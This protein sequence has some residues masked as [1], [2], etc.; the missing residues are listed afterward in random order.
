MRT[1]V[2]SKWHSAELPRLQTGRA[3][4]LLELIVLLGMLLALG[5]T[6][7]PALARSKADSKLTACAANF[8]QWGASVN[9]YAQDQKGRLPRPYPDPAGGGMYVWDA[10]TNLCNVMIPYGL[11]LPTWFCPVR[12]L[13]AEAAVNWARLNLQHPILSLQ[14]IVAF[15]NHSFSAE[16]I[17]NHNWWVPRAQAQQL[18]PQDYSGKPP[19]LQPAFGRGSDP[20]LYGWP[21]RVDDRASAFVPFISDKCGSGQGS[22]FPISWT[23]VGTTVDCICNNTAHFFNGVLFGVNAAFVDGH[24]EARRPEKMRCVYSNGSTYWFY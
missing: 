19:N 5:A 16:I 11:T 3:F 18:Y 24:V 6:L 2:N 13:E 10:S 21:T 23:P 9:L 7:L 4:T 22:G 15:F 12:P 17:M 8:R 14:D 20:F 1:K